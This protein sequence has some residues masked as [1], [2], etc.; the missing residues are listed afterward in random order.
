M[1]GRNRDFR[2][3]SI[4]ISRLGANIGPHLHVFIKE[5]LSKGHSLDDIRD[6]LVEYGFR[7]DMV[8]GLLRKYLIKSFFCNP[9]FFLILI[10]VLCSLFAPIVLAEEISSPNYKIGSYSVS[11]GGY[12]ISSPTYKTDLVVSTI[13]GNVTSTLYKLFL[14]FFY[15]T[16]D[17][18]PPTYTN[19]TNNASILTLINGDVNWSI[20]LADNQ[21]LSG[22]IFAHNNSGTWTNGSYKAIGGSAASYFVNET[23]SITLGYGNYICGQF[24]FN[25]TKGNF[26]QTLINESC[27]TVAST[28]PTAPIIYYPVNGNNYSDIPYI[29]YSSTDADSSSLTYEIYINGSLNATLV[30]ANL[31]DWNASDGYYN[32]TVVA[33]DGLS[34]SDNSTV[35]EFRLD[36]TTPVVSITSPVNDSRFNISSVTFNVSIS[37]SV[38][39]CGLSIDGGANIS[40]ELNSSR[41]GANYTNSSVEDGKHTFTVYC[42]DSAG[43]L[44]TATYDLLVD[45]IDPN[46]YFT[47]V[48]PGNGSFIA[49]DHLIVNVSVNDSSNV[50]VF[51]DFDNSL[52]AWY[53]FSEESLMNGSTLYDSSS[54]G[55]NGT[56][57]AN[58]SS[59]NGRDIGT[60]AGYFGRGGNFDGNGDYVDVGNDSSLVLSG[61]N[62]TFSAW[63]YPTSDSG[64]R[65]IFAKGSITTPT[66]GWVA[67][68]QNNDK[69]WFCQGSCQPG[70]NPQSTTSITVNQWWH[71]VG[72]LSGTTAD[73]YVN[74]VLE[75]DDANFDTITEEPGRNA[76]IGAYI[77]SGSKTGYF[78]GT[79]DDVMVFNRSLSAEEVGALYANQTSKYYSHN[80]TLLSDG[81]H[82]FKAYTQDLGGNIN[83]TEDRIVT[84]DTL[85]PGIT[86]NSPMNS[87]RFNHSSI[88]FNWTSTDVLSTNISCN[89]TIDGN[90]NQ[91]NITVTS[92][93]AY[94]LTVHNIG[95]GIHYWNVSCWDNANNMNNSDTYNFLVDTIY[96]NISFITPPTPADD[97]SQK[98]NHI[99]INVSAADSGNMS[100]FVDF[101]S[102]LVGWW[103]FDSI[104]QSGKGALVYDSSEYMN[105]GTAQADAEQTDAGYFG[106]AFEFDGAGDYIEVADSQ[107]LNITGTEITMAAWIR[108]GSSKADMKIIYKTE[109]NT[110]GYVT[111]IY[112]SKYESYVFTD[113][114]NGATRGL[115]TR[116]L[117]NDSKWHFVVSVYNGTNLT[118]YIDGVQYGDSS[119]SNGSI[120]AADHFLAI[121]RY[122]VSGTH[123]FNGTIDN[124]MIFNRSLSIEEI[125]GLYANQSS[126][127]MVVN[128]SNL[129]DGNHTFMAYVQDLGGN[130]NSTETREI[131]IDSTAPNVTIIYPSNNTNISSNSIVLNA[132]AVEN[133]AT[134]LTYYWYINGSLNSTTVDSNSTFD[135]SEGYYNL[136]LFVSDGLQNGS[137]TV[138]FKIDTSIPIIN[139]TYPGDAANI[140]SN[141]IDLNVST[142]ES[143]LTLY[144]T[145]NGSL[146]STTVDSNSSLNASDGYYNLTLFASDG[147]QNGSDTIF[148][149]LDAV[150]PSWSGNMTNA[151]TVGI[152]GNVTFNINVSDYGSGLSYHIF[153]WNGTGE[154]WLNYTNGSIQGNSVRLVV[155][156]S[157]NLS[158]GNTVGYRWYANDSAGNW[159][160]SLLRTFVVVNSIPT[161]PLVDYPSD[162]SSYVSLPYINYTSTDMDED[163]LTY[164]I[165]INGSLNITGIL[166]N[167]TDWNSSEGYYNLTVV[168]NDGVDS[169]ANSS[170]IEFRIDNV[171]PSFSDNRTNASFDTYDGTDVQ[172]NLTINDRGVLDYYILSHN[173]T[174][175]GNWTNESAVGI[176]SGSM[177]AVINYS[178]TDFSIEGGTFGWRIWVNDSLGNVNVSEIYTL[179]IRNKT[180]GPAVIATSPSGIVRT[181]TFS[182]NATTDEDARCR[183]IPS[184][185]GDTTTSY[186]DMPYN[187][188]GTGVDHNVTLT[189]TNGNY[190]YYV[191]C[192]NDL[193]NVMSE[194]AV[195]SFTVD[196]ETIIISVPSPSGGGGGGGTIDVDVEKIVLLEFDLLSSYAMFAGEERDIKIRLMNLGEV[197]LKSI[198]LGV[199]TDSPELDLSLSERFIEILRVGERYEFMLKARSILDAN[200][201]IGTGNRYI[202]TVNADPGYIDY[203]ESVSFFVDVIEKDYESRIET[204]K[205]MRFVEDLFEEEPDCLKFDDMVK[206]AKEYYD[207]SKYD[208]SLAEIEE[209]IQACRDEIA[210][211]EEEE[212]EEK[213]APQERESRILFFILLLIIL[214]LLA[215]MYYYYRKKKGMVVPERRKGDLYAQFIAL[216][217]QTKGFVRKND[218]ARAQRGYL[219]LYALYKN[220][221]D[222]SLSNPIKAD[223]YRKLS[224][225]HLRLSKLRRRSIK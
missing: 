140:S 40:M 87:S 168:A 144:W 120:L 175:D 182:M 102:S 20:N 67:L 74:G 82:S 68:I 10:F 206:K 41:T 21:G 60:A 126:R 219:A 133:I 66:D 32:L 26:N 98:E 193:G 39:W 13:A 141:S 221:I 191:R 220:V 54:Y 1:L 62:F 179:V 195:I 145:V 181:F 34:S 77:L 210:P 127:Y 107:S 160:E 187:F 30:D 111:G 128:F 155:N 139:I 108:T 142:L 38:E 90:V 180:E 129:A 63:V 159:N 167:V 215:A 6:A 103:T 164:D 43:N 214:A 170:V 16:K 50:S 91:S 146:N 185:E 186:Y 14:G 123:Y 69:F 9:L 188:S 101:D 169:S 121:G 136:T 156:K 12:N 64:D 130:I 200:A 165:Y 138:F 176:G 196:V 25:D 161:T 183:Y 72:V 47:N 100:V 132:S 205:Q 95:E 96:P 79:I 71:V 55:N 99:F 65:T 76:L 31:T 216:F 122:D 158:Q 222:S 24:W 4:D 27:F 53:R 212:E 119:G 93:A 52:I 115:G 35:V 131:K 166:E 147:L 137:D 153:S 19:F 157:T 11:S 203:R 162:S 23:V 124:V 190:T 154:G 73:V 33:N 192:A 92:G 44:G 178:I 59:D 48:T 15:T 7:E 18:S 113:D 28:S 84:I 17:L 117:L 202:V 109:D 152:N 172:L 105:N 148:F 75:S 110:K 189:L 5:N 97:S 57:Y 135:G 218:V 211:E 36:S 112:E 171:G 177:E 225:L 51:V 143:G 174:T 198:N 104:N 224:I 223:C 207:E 149:R 204:E 114:T 173:D 209:A 86:L 217:N 88:V 81:E 61:S 8:G 199:E 83:A 22:Y 45:T 29:N 42:N 49:E 134:S 70:E 150:A 213:P 37:E 118:D 184:T 163:S 151:T 85:Y 78:N 58:D 94:N 106:K 194:S 208:D 3:K 56:V 116:A 89:L 46:I 80:F 125:R 197:S 2:G 201:R